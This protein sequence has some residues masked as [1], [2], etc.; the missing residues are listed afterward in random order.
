MKQLK[1]AILNAFHPLPKV[2][3]LSCRLRLAYEQTCPQ[4]ME[5]LDQSLQAQYDRA[6]NPIGVEKSV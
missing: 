5:V 1:Y 3:D 6:S 4:V 2:V